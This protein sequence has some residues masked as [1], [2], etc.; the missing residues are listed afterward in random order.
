M[1]IFRAE[2]VVPVTAEP[3]QDG[4][5]VFKDD[6]IIEVGAFADLAVKFPDETVNDFGVSAIIPG[7]VNC[8][9]H[10]ELTGFRGSVDR[11]DDDFTSW[12]YEITRLRRDRDGVEEIELSALLGACEGAA[13]GVTTFGDIGRV[14]AAGVK[15]LHTTGLRGIVFQ[16]TEFSPSISNADLDLGLLKSKFENLSEAGTRLVRVGISPHAPYTVSA[17]L[18]EGIAAYSIENSIPISIHAAESAAETELMER[19]AGVFKMWFERESVDW[20]S[21][22]EST[23]RFLA[24]I[25]VLE[26]KPLLAHCIRVSDQEIELI[27]KSGSRVAHCPKSNAKF[28]HGAAPLTGFLRRGAVVG[29]GSDSMASNNLCDLFEEARF[30][31]LLARVVDSG[32]EFLSAE[33]L[34]MLATMGGAAALGMETE[35]GS[36]EAGKQADLTVISVEGNGQVPVYDI[37]SVLVFSTSAASVIETVVG[38]RSIYSRGEMTRVDMSEVRTQASRVFSLDNSKKRIS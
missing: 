4:A 15:A 32:S 35:I 34:L 1:P 20:T 5:V 11:H 14:G 29:L 18:F 22:R 38:G 23:I 12:L 19:D 7:L 8:H 10:L 36:L 37:C 24:R 27:V 9:S 3:I 6:V 30:A 2:Y 25:G 17:R 33:Q 26:A 21:P 31:G 13:S 28:G 16:E